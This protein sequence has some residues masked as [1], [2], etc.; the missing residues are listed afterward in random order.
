MRR[1]V[2][3]MVL[4]LA[5]SFA[6]TAASSPAATT[7]VQITKTGFVPASVTINANDAVTWKNADKVNHQV[8]ANGGQFASPIQRPAAFP[9]SEVP[10][11][12]GVGLGGRPNGG[13]GPHRF[14]TWAE[15]P[16]QD[17]PKLAQ[18][19]ADQDELSR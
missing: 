19:V 10:T 18:V 1:L 12:Q 3:G 2:F 13:S 7:T 9:P 17:G 15:G 16:Q 4:A 14:A 6:A 8:V 5:L 11:P